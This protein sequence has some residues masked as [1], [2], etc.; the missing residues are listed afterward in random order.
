MSGGGAGPR[1]LALAHDKR[2]ISWAQRPQVRLLKTGRLPGQ[3]RASEQGG[4]G[5]FYSARVHKQVQLV[6]EEEHLPL[7][8]P[9]L[10]QHALQGRPRPP[11]D[12]DQLGRQCS[13][14]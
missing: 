3:G 1:L 6:Y 13:V 9:H 14:C 7:G 2:R 11:H 12:L 5:T 8:G 10:P 4:A